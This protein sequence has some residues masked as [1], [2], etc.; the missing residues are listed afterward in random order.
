[1][2]SREWIMEIPSSKNKYHVPLLWVNWLKPADR[3]FLELR[4]DGIISNESSLGIHVAPSSCACIVNGGPL[5]YW[6]RISMSISRKRKCENTLF[7]AEVESERKEWM[8]R[9]TTAETCRC[10]WWMRRS[11]QLFTGEP[12]IN[13]NTNITLR[14][15][16]SRAQSSWR[17]RNVIQFYINIE[18]IITVWFITWS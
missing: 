12:R 8:E 9:T 3:R 18:P 17:K 4:L 13:N 6:I 5:Q 7:S 16:T 14:S 1:M 11:E 15:T 2:S 10:S